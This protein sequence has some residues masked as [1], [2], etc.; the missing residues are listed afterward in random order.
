MN[1]ICYFL[2]GTEYCCYD[3]TNSVAEVVGYVPTINQGRAPAGTGGTAYEELNHLSNSWKESF[4]GTVSAIAY[5]LYLPADSIEHVWVNGTEVTTGFSLGVDN[6]TVT[7]D[8][9]P[10]EGTNNVVIQGTKA[11]SNDPDS[12]IKCTIAQEWGGKNDTRVFFSGNSD[13]SNR[14]WHSQV[15]AGGIIDATYFPINNWDDIGSNA[16][17]ITGMGRLVDYQVIYKKRT[18]QYSSV[19]GPDDTTGYMS[20]PAL[21]M[22]DEYGCI[23]PKTVCPAQGGLLALSE[24]GVTFTMASTFTRGQ[25]NV[26]MVSEKV[27]H[28]SNNDTLGINDFT[29]AEREAAH[30]FIYDQKYWLHIKDRVWILD[31][32]YSSLMERIY[33]WYPYNAIPG[34]ASCF[35][36][37]GEVLYVG[38]DVAGLIYS[39]CND[40]S[41]SPY[42]DDGVLIDAYWTS[43]MT[44]CKARDWIKRFEQLNV[45]YGGQAIAN[46]LLSFITEDGV[47]DIAVAYTDSRAFDFDNIDF[48]DWTFGSTA[49]PA[50]S[51]EK[52]GYKGEYLQWKIRNNVIDEGLVI[53]GQTL[54]YSLAKRVR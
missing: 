35:M 53:L 27:N 9:A 48:D 8:V 30:A 7:F 47:E 50:T 13:I 4:N 25:L 32:K 52:V 43:P 2:T 26:L 46:H 49:Y 1:D 33:C 22:N 29:M 14:R 34:K 38:D 6:V 10:G 51:S 37:S 45:T 31:L 11:D 12:I 5:V 42:R 15:L 28:S 40:E 24:Q 44:F 39:I 17:A 54:L 23:A 21:P 16:E 20:F 19:V 36:E 18:T 3:G 41:T